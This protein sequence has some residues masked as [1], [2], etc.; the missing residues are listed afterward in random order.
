MLAGDSDE[1][2]ARSDTV[3]IALSNKLKALL[4]VCVFLMTDFVNRN[5][6]IP[7]FN[8]RVV[9]KC[10][11]SRELR[12]PQF[13]EISLMSHCLLEHV[14]VIYNVHIPSLLT[15]TISKKV[16]FVKSTGNRRKHVK[17]DV[18]CNLI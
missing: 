6:L 13:V 17:L 3:L 1:N 2:T 8:T 7:V 18:N 5:P 16:F 4:K 9:V 12:V 14:N 11:I 15:L 10:L